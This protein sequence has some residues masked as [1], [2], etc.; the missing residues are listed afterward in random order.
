MVAKGRRVCA[1]GLDLKLLMARYSAIGIP[2]HSLL[3]RRWALRW[4]LGPATRGS[5]LLL[6]IATGGWG[7]T[8]TPRLA[9]GGNGPGH[10]YTV[11][12]WSTKDGLPADRVR[13]LWQDKQGF[14]WIA[15]FNGISRFDGVRFRNHD[16]SNTPGL[17]NN[18]VNALYEDRGGNLWLGHDTGEISVL[19]R[20]R[21]EKLQLDPQWRG[22]P[23]DQFGETADG[24]VWARNRLSW[25]LPI[26]G[27]QPGSIRKKVSG[28]EISD[29]AS[30][31]SGQLW[32]AG[33][34]GVF[35][36]ESAAVSERDMPPDLLLPY[37]GATPV[38]QIRP[39]GNTNPDI[40][41][42]WEGPAQVFRARQ[43][44]VW[45]A[46]H[47]QVRRWA[48]GR[49]TGESVATQ[50]RQRTWTNTW[51]EL[52]D[53]RLAVSTYDEGLQ[54][55]LPSNTVQQL[56]AEHGLPADYVTALV[57]DRE[58]NLWIGAGDQGLCRLR[59]SSIEMMSPPDGWGN[60]SVQTVI[61]ARD[62]SVWAGTEGAGI[63][64]LRNGTWTHLDRAAGLTNLAVKT[65]LEDPAGR[66]WAGLTNGDFGVFEDDKFRPMFTDQ[67]VGPITAVFQTR[68]GEMWVGGLLGVG[69]IVQDRLEVVRSERGRLAQ[70]SGFA[71]A[72]D[73]TVWIASVGNGLGRYQNGVLEL[74]RKDE[75]LPSDYVWSLHSGHDGTL[76]IGTYDRG[77]VAYR[78]G[79]FRQIATTHGIPGNMVAQIIA[80]ES[81]ALWLGTNGGIARVRQAE[82]ERFVSGKIER[83]SAEVFE[84]SEGLPTRALSGG[85]QAGACRTPDGLLWFATDRGLARIDPR[86]SPPVAPLPP[87]IIETIRID[88]SEVSA[89]GSST[90]H[91]IRME[92]GSRRLEIEY[93]GLNLTSPNRVLFRYRMEGADENWNEAETRR[94]AYFSYLRPGRYVFRVQS[95]SGD[96]AGGP[97]ASLQV[98]VEPQFWETSWFVALA[99]VGS[100]GLVAGVVYG[101]TH[102]RHRRQI[103]RIEQVHAIER[104]RTRIAHDIHDEIGSGLTQLSILSHSAQ[105][106]ETKEGERAGRLR[107]IEKTVTEMTAAIDEIVWAVNPRHDSLESLISYLC[108]VVQEFAR[109]VGLQCN[110]D[111]PYDLERLEV[112]AEFRHELYLVVREAL[113]N[114]TKHAAATEVRFSVASEPDGFVFR[115]EDNGC[116]FPKETTAPTTAVP[117]GVGL[118]SMRQRITKLGGTLSCTN[119]AEGGAVVA[120][121]VAL[122]RRAGLASDPRL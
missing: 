74:L 14:M 121:R 87:V 82:L 34:K 96:G 76:W 26:S 105:A 48:E 17:A 56:D 75:G 13:H 103:A 49:W 112:T 53:G 18:L 51:M 68:G 83:V 25:L 100:L 106:A 6:A 89:A 41:M 30:G 39:S 57:E 84:L 109:R 27:V 23:V 66:I 108:G 3:H 36:L 85:S 81:G 88:G 63:Y 29:I 58:G 32:L 42:R 99:A 20:G 67:A 71:E 1:R 72:E 28:Q 64:R 113:H 95:V 19:R 9:P 62:G 90:H 104:D 79:R 80:D 97:E 2:P 40:P 22:S 107:E 7:A 115:L 65:M 102:S 31:D 118:E 45:V 55:M 70:I 119:R 111:A 43:G 5:C 12:S 117:T 38:P 69:R 86:I 54:F 59:P 61:A 122:K 4:S 116:G 120:F 114:V 50:V 52:A 110:I 47:T 78:D 94:T 46:D 10:T 93:T 8:G 15:T 44:G 92:P 60:W 73:G 11:T 37:G 33:D 77:L 98:D 16:V 21:F 101:V 91:S 35:S 24:T